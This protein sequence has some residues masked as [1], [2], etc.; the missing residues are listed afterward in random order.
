MAHFTTRGMDEIQAPALSGGLMAVI[1]NLQAASMGIQAGLR[2]LAQA[3]ALLGL[4]L[5]IP[6]LFDPGTQKVRIR[7]FPGFPSRP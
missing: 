4:A 5:S 3:T 7:D 2:L 6:L 1:V